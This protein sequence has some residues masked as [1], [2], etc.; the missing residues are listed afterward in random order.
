MYFSNFDEVC[1]Y[2]E[3]LTNLSKS[4]RFTV[5]TYRLDRMKALLDHFD[6]PE[7]D[8]TTIHVAGSKGKGSTALYISKG[9]RALGYRTGLYASPHVTTY[10][11]RFTLSG[12]FFDDHFLLVTATDMINHIES[13]HFKEE[14]GYTQPTTFELLTLLGFLLFS[15][16]DCSYAVIET[17]LGGRLDATN[18]ITPIISVITSIELEHT[19]VLGDTIQKIAAEKAG[20]IKRGV[21]VAVSYQK[22]EI[23]AVLKQRAQEQS[24]SITSLSEVVDRIE[25]TTSIIGENTAIYW[26]DYPTDSL[27][28]AM[29][30]SFQAENAALAILVL[31]SLKLFN[32][33][34]C[35][36]AIARAAIPGRLEL[37]REHPSIYIDGAHTAHSIE[38]VFASFRS[39]YPTGGVLIFGAVDGKNHRK[40]AEFAL[41]NFSKIVISTPGNFKKSDP[42]KLFQLFLALRD[43][44]SDRKNLPD[45]YLIPEPRL[46]LDA[47]VNLTD[48]HHG[49]ILTAGSFY[50]AAEIRN[51]VC[52]N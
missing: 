50:M 16:S 10:R 25:S 12:L 9:L 35:L 31:R 46:A 33:E 38:R 40:M 52:C 32:S 14:Y 41:Q 2:I 51:L 22:E 34:R 5:K 11:E 28:L 6:H 42:K 39:I 27:L 17:G 44:I 37:I 48:A 7:Q 29:R 26:K 24:S 49:V 19:E 21:P 8:F 45:I 36:P 1:T 4:M 15:K 30:G 3:S 23:L 20:I 18:V 43:T 13:F 47:A